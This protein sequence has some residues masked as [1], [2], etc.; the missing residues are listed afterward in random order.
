[1]LSALISCA[2]TSTIRLNPGYD[3]VCSHL[4]T[5]GQTSDRLSL[6][7]SAASASVGLDTL[8]L[9]GRLGGNRH[10]YPKYGAFLGVVEKNGTHFTADG[11]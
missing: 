7:L 8:M 3:R 6:G 9:S 10:R 11:Q 1:M 5:R 2:G 4:S